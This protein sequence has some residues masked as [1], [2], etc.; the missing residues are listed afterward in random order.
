MIHHVSIGVCNI[1]TAKTFYD[2][3][4]KP[5]GYSYLS[6]SA[7]SLGD[8]KDA[9]A[10][11]LSTTKTPVAADPGSALHFCFLAPNRKSLDSFHTAALA[12]G[13]QDNGKPGLRADCGDNS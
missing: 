3:A 5:L 4:L 12:A 13:G 9:V 7:A 2:A 6:S 11:W 10:F 1:A 8:G